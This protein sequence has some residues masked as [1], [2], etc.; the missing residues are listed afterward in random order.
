MYLELSVLAGRLQ[1][2]V[3]EYARLRGETDVGREAESKLEQIKTSVRRV[4]LD[5]RLAP[6]SALLM[7]MQLALGSID[8]TLDLLD[9]GE[10][11]G[12]DK[13]V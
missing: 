1:G 5:I 11:G 6:E 9:G 7:G 8:E 3:G 13:S 10:S 2:A 12:V 4:G